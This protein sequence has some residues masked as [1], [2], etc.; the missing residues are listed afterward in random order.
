[1]N[2]KGESHLPELLQRHESDLLASW[3]QG[4]MAAFGSSGRIQGSELRAECA[5]FFGHLRKAAE[6]GGADRH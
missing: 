4:Q 2:N 6:G 3:I 5:E 1:M